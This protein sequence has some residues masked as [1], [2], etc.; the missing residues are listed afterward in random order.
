MR[1]R[2]VNLLYLLL[3]SVLLSSCGG[4]EKI[5]KSSDVNYKL[6]KANE[7]FDKKDYSH[8]NQLYKEL[9]PIMKSTRN[10][11]ALFYKYAFTF[12]Y[13]KDYVEASYYFKNFTDYFPSS[14]ETEEC[15]F[16][17]A[18]C[19]FKYAPK[20]TLDQSNSM[21][22]LEAL[23]AFASKY[24]KSTKLAEA[25]D[26]IAKSKYKLE[27]KQADAAK[28]YFNINQFKAASVAYRSV[29]HN[30]PES[31]NTDLYQFM[32]MKAMYKYA[33]ASIETKQ[34]ERYASA[35]SAYRELKEAYPQSKYIPEADKLFTLADNNVK[36]IRDEQHK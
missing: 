26:Y 6:T 12:Y 25:N 35:I 23:Q 19:L 5:R 10:Y 8:A 7:Y 28:L 2:T 16:M 20:S 33:K 4:F 9:M 32:I 30:Y 27:S 34:E 24:P 1:L 17:S 11:E 22:S 18:V 3:F 36:K 14:K 31:I 15:E 13:L 21:K 29:M